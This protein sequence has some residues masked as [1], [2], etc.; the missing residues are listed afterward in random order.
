MSTCVRAGPSSKRQPRSPAAR[1]RGDRFREGSF[2]SCRSV[3]GLVV[4]WS[5]WIPRP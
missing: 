5:T 1:E 2:R 4:G 3:R